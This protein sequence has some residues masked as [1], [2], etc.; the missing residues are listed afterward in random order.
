MTA[1]NPRA[2]LLAT[3]PDLPRWVD[4]RGLLL[5]ERGVVVDL[6]DGCR[7]V[8]GRTD[9]LVI[10]VTIE[11]S[12]LLEARV[13]DEVTDPTILLQDVMLPAARYHL[14]DWIAEATTLYTLP[15]DLRDWSP[16]E[17]P[18]ASISAT[19]IGA[20]D[21]PT[22]LRDELLDAAMRGQ[23]WCAALDGQPVSFAYAAQATE[24]WFDMSVN[25]LERARN[26]GLGRAAAIG[27]IVDRLTR[28]QRPV[29]RALQGDEPSHRLARR[30][31]F[32][33]VDLLWTLT[34][35]A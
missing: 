21:L 33:P 10:P 24:A 18:T 5:A 12:P 3:L 32:E 19:Q 7:M 14:P 9:R 31:G 13:I 15:S 34:R 11:L 1:T 8:C 28:G 30:L 23:V 25:T 35:R 4:A 16:I 17:C 22:V 29:W 20:A 27:L 6:P 26:R 2:D